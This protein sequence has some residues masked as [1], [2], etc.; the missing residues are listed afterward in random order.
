[1]AEGKVA[2]EDAPVVLDGPGLV[3]LFADGEEEVDCLVKGDRVGA[4]LPQRTLCEEP[5]RDLP[6]FGKRDQG[7]PADRDQLAVDAELDHKA[8]RAALRD[9][10]AEVRQYFIEVSALS[11]LRELERP[12]RHV[13]QLHDMKVRCAISLSLASGKGCAGVVFHGAECTRDDRKMKQTKDFHGH[14]EMPC[15]ER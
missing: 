3:L 13:G 11:L 9:A 7:I 15:A 8:A 6:R 14:H 10:A 4:K 2:L 12:D 1:M 5:L